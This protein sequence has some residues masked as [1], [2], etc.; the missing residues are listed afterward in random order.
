MAFFKSAGFDYVTAIAGFYVGFGDT[1]K[2]STQEET[3]RTAVG[4]DRIRQWA[5]EHE[6]V[7]TD[8]AAFEKYQ[9]P[10]ADDFDYTPWKT[11][12][13]ILPAGMKAIALLGK[14]YTPVWMLM[15][16]AQRCTELLS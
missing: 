16:A 1:G 12:D 2:I 13:T 7:M 11:F 15:G 3:V 5:N 10:S 9:W 4:E 14:I 8:W 6:G